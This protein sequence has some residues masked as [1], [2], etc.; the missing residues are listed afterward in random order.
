MRTSA[1]LAMALAATV[2]GQHTYGKAATLKLAIWNRGT[3]HH[4]LVGSLARPSGSSR[5]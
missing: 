5:T 4:V 1:S 3:L 2:L